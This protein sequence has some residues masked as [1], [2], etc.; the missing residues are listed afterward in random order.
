MSEARD[1][2]PEELEDD[3]QPSVSEHDE[4]EHESEEDDE[5]GE[6]PAPKPVDWEKRAH[7]ATPGKPLGRRSKRQAAERRAQELETRLE[8][9]EAQSGDDELLT[10]IAQLR[11]D[12]EDPVGDIAAVEAGAEALW[13]ARGDHT[14]EQQRATGLANRQVQAVR[15]SM[16]D[17]EVGLRGRSCGLSRGGGLLPKKELSGRRGRELQ[18]AGYHGEALQGAARD[19]LFGLVRTAFNAG[20]DPAERVYNLAKKRG[21]KAGGKAADR[22]LDALDR[23]GATGVRPQAR[24]VARAVL[25]W[26]DV[27]K[28]DGPAVTRPGRSFANANMARK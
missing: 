9:I 25:S 17:A 1:E 15:E 6:R 11:D 5:E 21:F 3:G 4:L 10:L 7:S 28:L 8:K 26:A 27:A 22:K 12:D 18:E 16:A 20:L 24:G 14:A 13:P 19:D 2:T 23:T